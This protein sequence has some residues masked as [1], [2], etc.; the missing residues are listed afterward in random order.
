MP[1]SILVTMSA[2]APGEKPQ[3]AEASAN[4]TTPVRY[5]RRLPNRSPSVPPISRNAARIRV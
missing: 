1:C 4:H 5:T 3:A 2:S